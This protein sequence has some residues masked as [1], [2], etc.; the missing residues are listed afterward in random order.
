MH[1][2]MPAPAIKFETSSVLKIWGCGHY[3]CVSAF[4]QVPEPRLPGPQEADVLMCIPFY[5]KG[6]DPEDPP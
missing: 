3:T 1:G 6:L 5:V 2:L 4:H